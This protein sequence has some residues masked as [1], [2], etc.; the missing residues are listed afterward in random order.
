MIPTINI[1]ILRASDKL[2][3]FLLVLKK[4]F[5]TMMV[6]YVLKFIV[7]KETIVSQRFL[8]KKCT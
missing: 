7:I 4:S 3:I 1:N 5:L 8:V 2:F 6:L